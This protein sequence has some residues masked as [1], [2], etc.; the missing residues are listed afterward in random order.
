[1]VEAGIIEPI[2][3]SSWYPTLLSSEIILVT[4]DCVLTLGT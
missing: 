4:L 2:I 1:M 3:Y